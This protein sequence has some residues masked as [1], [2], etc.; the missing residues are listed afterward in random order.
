LARQRL[1]EWAREDLDG[2]EL[3]DAKLLTSELV[4][5]ALAHG[6]GMVEMR[7]Q[8]DHNRLLVDVTDQGEGFEGV[9][10][11]QNLKRSVDGG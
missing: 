8:L 2:R 4:T 11:E 9:E 6:S 3:E 10:C 7:G 5:N 1:V